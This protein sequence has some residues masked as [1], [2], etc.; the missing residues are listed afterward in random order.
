M[1]YQKIDL[2]EHELCNNTQRFLYLQEFTRI[3]GSWVK[4]EKKTDEKKHL[5]STCKGSSQ[6]INYCG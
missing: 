5:E 2:A 6:S 3:K 4:S 1:D